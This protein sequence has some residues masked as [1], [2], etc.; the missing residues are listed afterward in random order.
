MRLPPF[1]IVPHTADIGLVVRG[2]DTT[3]LLVNSGRGLNAILFRSPPSGRDI[4]RD[5][6]IESAD[7]DTLLVD[8]LNE[9]LYLLDGERLAFSRFAQVPRRAVRPRATPP[10]PGRQG[11]DVPH[12]GHSTGRR[13]VR[14]ACH[15]GHLR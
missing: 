15:T 12:G 5:V 9:L 10:H 1:E 14:G 6:H 11:G 2:R 3:E 7:A 8:W 4:E 13:R